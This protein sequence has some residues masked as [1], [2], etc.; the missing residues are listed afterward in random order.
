M[1]KSRV[2][3]MEKT[4][5]EVTQE[6]V[7]KRLDIFVSEHMDISRSHIKNLIDDG[8][9]TINGKNKKSGCIEVYLVF[10]C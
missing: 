7:G 9:V 10:Y 1:P 8:K 4:E 3:S 2:D 5:F 6:G